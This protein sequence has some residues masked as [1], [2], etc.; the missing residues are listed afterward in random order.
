MAEHKSVRPFPLGDKMSW[1][2]AAKNMAV[3]VIAKVEGAG[4]WDAINYNDPITIGLMQWYG[5]RAAG[6]L[7]AIRDGNPTEYAKFSASLRDDVAANP[8]NS[9]WWTTRFLDPD[10]EGRTLKPVLRAVK[11]IQSALVASDIDDYKAVC[12]RIGLDAENNTNTAIFFMVMYHQNPV[13]AINLMK[14]IGMSSS[15]SRTYAACINEDVYSGFVGR[16]TQA[17][18]YISSGIPPVIIDLNDEDSELGDT[19]NGTGSD[20]NGLPSIFDPAQTG[21]KYLQIVGD[22]ILIKLADNSTAFATATG[23]NMFIVNASYKGDNVPEE[24]GPGESTGPD[25]TPDPPTGDPA[26]DRENALVKFMTDRTNKYRYSQGPSRLTP[27]SQ[28]ATDCS[29][30]TRFAYLTVTGIDIGSYT[31]AQLSSNTTKTIT[32]GGGGNSPDPALL[33]R[34][35]L[36]I[37]RRYGTPSNRSASHVE[38][39][40]GGGQIIGHGGPGVG[41]FAKDLAARTADKQRW[42][43]K[44]LK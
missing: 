23:T 2:A 22:R 16:Y 25:P 21:I 7:V 18:D 39:Y 33:R 17:R 35:D 40:M 30:L 31:D 41:P 24:V 28:N 29:G 19:G 42:W 38:I 36:V 10:T 15:L 13:R 6:L 12:D 1:D 3:N 8:A 34:G 27:D 9:R 11:D 5:T 37:S 32:S 4:A 26:T 43:V 20:G 44:R 14:K